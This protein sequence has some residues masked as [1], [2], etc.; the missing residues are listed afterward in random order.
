MGAIL[1]DEC[2]P[3]ATIAT[4][5]VLPDTTEFSLIENTGI[6]QRMIDLWRNI[7]NVMA[8]IKKVSTG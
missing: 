6:C 2:C 4:P 5:Y 1:L 8:D 7:E 3:K